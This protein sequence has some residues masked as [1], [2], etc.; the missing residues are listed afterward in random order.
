MKPRPKAQACDKMLLFWVTA[1][2]GII[3]EKLAGKTRLN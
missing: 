2:C 3:A 1:A